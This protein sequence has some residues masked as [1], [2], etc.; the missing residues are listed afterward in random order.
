MLVSVS[1]HAKKQP[2][3]SQRNRARGLWMVSLLVWW[4]GVGGVGGGESQR[5]WAVHKPLV[6]MEKGAGHV[7]APRFAIAP[8]LQ[9]GT[10]E[11]MVFCFQSDVP[12]VGV[13]RLY[14]SA[15]P[16]GDG[17]GETT[18]GP[19]RAGANGPGTLLQEATSPLATQH[20]V[21]VTGLRPGTR[22]RY[23]VLI[24]RL[25]PPLV[26]FYTVESLS[27]EAEFSTA[28]SSGSFVFLVYGDNRD[29]DADHAAVIAAMSKEHP[30]FVL[31]T[32]DMVSRANNEAQWRRYFATAAPIL[33][34][35]PIYPTLGNHELRGE[36][37]ASHFFRL[38]ALP[39][40][41]PP[42]RRPVYY[43]FRFGNALFVSLDANSPHDGGQASWLEH[44]LQKAETNPTIRHV[45]V[46]MHQPPFA[47]GSYCGSQRLLNRIVPI[48]SRHR[49]RAVFAGH[50]H[51]YQHL[52]RQQVRYFITGGG[53]APLYPRRKSCNAADDQSL[54]L[55][56][57]EHH[58]LRVEVNGDAAVLTAINTQGATIDRVA[59]HQPVHDVA[60]TAALALPLSEPE[61]PLHSSRWR[62][63]VMDLL[64]AQPTGKLVLMG[65]SGLT[66]LALALS[67]SGL[68][69][70]RR[71]GGR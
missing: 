1:H 8:Y 39:G 4:W 53:G 17:T 13:V 59:L 57:A 36:L 50:E 12:T 14:E 71:G 26:P 66:L 19:R 23:Q 54:W 20:R 32:G 47:V 33:A 41:V 16:A 68:R 43:V 67:A 34:R 5:A 40:P 22:Y 63:Q 48:L 31:Q 27:A 24:R 45:F 29:R 65:L 46:F 49:I 18:D 61:V 25:S 2:G 44:Q 56:R 69:R 28:P 6:A 15:E 35:A 11:S 37:S 58:Y 52:E 9:D 62:Q 21:R 38:F 51:A 42:T 60:L 30:D 10:P 3:L 64:K 7:A 70:A 55:F